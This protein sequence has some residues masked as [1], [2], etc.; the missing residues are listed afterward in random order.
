MILRRIPAL[1]VALPRT[2]T[3]TFLTPSAP[4]NRVFD[5]IRQPNDLHTLTLLNA[6][7]NRA[8]ITFWSASWCATCRTVKPLVR[9]LIESERVGEAEGGLGFVEVEMDS[10]LIG[11]LP[12][13]YRVRCFVPFELGWVGV[14]GTGRRKEKIKIDR[15]ADHESAYAP[16]VQQAGGPVRHQ[17]VPAAGYAEQRRP[18]PVVAE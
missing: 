15:C 5:S 3:R 13:T 17:A 2:Q 18:A 7:D 12:L 4:T 6:A 11:D 16:R 8:L 1:R 14:R 9:E 10:T